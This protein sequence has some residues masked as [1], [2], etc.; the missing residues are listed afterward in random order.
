VG[1]IE[2][3]SALGAAVRLFV[4]DE[5]RSLGI[6]AGPFRGG[7]FYGNPHNSMR[8]ILGLYEHELTGWIERALRSS[9]MVI[10]AGA[11]DG[12]FTLGSAAALRRLKKPVRVIGVDPD[13]TSLHRLGIARERNGYSAQEIQL[14]PKFVGVGDGGEFMSLDNLPEA[15][16]PTGALIKIDVEGW[17][18]DVI[19][20]AQRWLNPGNLFLIEVHKR[21][22]LDQLRSTFNGKGLELDLI[23]QRPVPL[24]GREQRSEE[25]WWL[26]SRLPMR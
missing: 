4:K 12:Y 13:A 16:D 7:A 26:V 25:N 18:I 22:F 23:E 10:D 21:E 1:E 14:I 11:N 9:R 15:A 24:L 3:V 2:P 6:L 20:G 8:K 5:D 19:A 17:E